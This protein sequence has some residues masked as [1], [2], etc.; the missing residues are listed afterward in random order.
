VLTPVVLAVSESV[1]TEA[2]AVTE[3]LESALMLDDSADAIEEIV[4]PDPLQLAESGCPFTVIVLVP[5]S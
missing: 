1:A 4:V 3:A 5:E 2:D